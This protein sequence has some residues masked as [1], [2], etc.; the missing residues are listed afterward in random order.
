MCTGKKQGTEKGIRRI[1]K[2]AKDVA[3]EGCG[4][5]SRHAPTEDAV[6]LREL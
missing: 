3:K 5:E 2:I 6:L 1:G 4:K